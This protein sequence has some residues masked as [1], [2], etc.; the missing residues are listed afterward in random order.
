M[1]EADPYVLAMARQIKLR[2]GDVRIV[3]QE[4]KDSPDK[5]SLNTAAGILGIASVPLAGFMHVEGLD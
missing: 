5:T 1:D 3:T 2:G 4:T